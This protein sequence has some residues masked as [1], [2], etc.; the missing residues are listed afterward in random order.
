MTKGKISLYIGCHFYGLIIPC[1]VFSKKV[2]RDQQSLNQTNSLLSGQQYFYF[3]IMRKQFS[4]V[5]YLAPNHSAINRQDSNPDP[6]VKIHDFFTLYLCCLVV[7]N[8]H[9][10]GHF[11]TSK[12]RR[13]F[14]FPG[15][16]RC[17]LTEQM[18]N[19]AI[20]SLFQ[21]TKKYA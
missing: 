7:V 4:E 3:T 2:E 15:S 14:L 19:L 5:K 21:L 18:R 16:R 9:L 6:S 1:A 12:Q 10:Y 17:G 13:R 11:C 20:F 8:T